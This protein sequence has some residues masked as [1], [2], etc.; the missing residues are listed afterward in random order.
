MSFQYQEN[1]LVPTSEER[2]KWFLS[3]F[4]SWWLLKYITRNCAKVC[5]KIGITVWLDLTHCSFF[6]FG[7]RETWCIEKNS[8]WSNCCTGQKYYFSNWLTFVLSKI[9]NAADV[10][11]M[12]VIIMQ[13]LCFVGKEEEVMTLTVSNC[14]YLP[15][16]PTHHILGM[17]VYRNVKVVMVYLTLTLWFA[18][19]TY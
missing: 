8:Y 2:P 14:D 16:L 11:K 18:L 9:R 6:C 13:C 5:R 3:H 4:Y 15:S 17:N 12:M 7:W 10:A 1:K 19:P